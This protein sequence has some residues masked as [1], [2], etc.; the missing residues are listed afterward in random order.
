MGRV[1]EGWNDQGERSDQ[2][3]EGGVFER[4]N[5]WGERSDQFMEGGVFERWND[6]GERPDQFIG[7]AAFEGGTIKAYGHR[8]IASVS[9]RAHRRLPEVH[10]SLRRMMVWSS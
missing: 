7:G 5:N 9:Q 1:F 6:Q 8:R 4:W 2:F 3:M 10:P